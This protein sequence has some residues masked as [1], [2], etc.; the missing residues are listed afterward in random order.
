MLLPI[1]SAGSAHQEIT[2][3]EPVDGESIDSGSVLV[4]SI[5]RG[6]E[7]PPFRRIK[8]E[9]AQAFSLISIQR[10]DSQLDPFL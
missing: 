9:L 5:H 7:T 4:Q 8:L 3:H 10:F 6:P 1:Q 2:D